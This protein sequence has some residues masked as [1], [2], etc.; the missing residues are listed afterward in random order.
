MSFSHLRRQFHRA[1]FKNNAPTV[2]SKLKSPVAKTIFTLALANSYVIRFEEDEVP[3]RVAPDKIQ[4][5][6]PHEFSNTYQLQQAFSQAVDSSVTAVSI[7]F[8]SY[9]TAQVQH[10][11]L[12]KAAIK[13]LM[14][15]LEISVTLC[16][17]LGLEEKLSQLQ[18]E[19]FLSRSTLS[20]GLYVF[21][22]SAKMLSQ[23]AGISFLVGNERSSG[24]ATAHLHNMELEVK[25]NSYP[26]DSSQS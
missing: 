19:I 7:S 4:I 22:E 16:E 11:V 9:T 26:K 12:L 17:H 2:S 15:G 3:N 20:D 18:S 6:E 21:E 8:R 10:I 14:T 24:L 25:D 23:A 5:P 13:T 1:L